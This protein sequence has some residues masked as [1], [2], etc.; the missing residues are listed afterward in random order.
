MTHDRSPA[1]AQQTDSDSFATIDGTRI[2]YRL[3]GPTGAPFLVLSNSLGTNLDMWEP[4]LAVFTTRFRVLRYDSRGHG[5]SEV[6]PGPYSIERLARDVVALQDELRIDRAHFCGLS[7][8]GMAGMWLGVHAPQRIDRLVLCNTAPRIGSAERW[9]S[10]IDAVNRGGV[11]GIADAL[12]EV[13]FTPRFRDAAADTVQR[14]RAMLI[15]SSTEGYVASCAAVRDMD[16]W[17]ALSRIDRPTLIVTGTH[18]ASAP[19]ADGRHMA[20]VIP[21][22]TLVELDAAHISNVEAAGRFTAEVLAFLDR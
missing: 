5:L 10:R 4:Q 9:N 21:G 15:A 6:T 22:A 3:D 16:Q 14:M 2:R 11:S 8:G 17:A 13:W 12:M 19:P 7:M 1:L 20:E 18:D